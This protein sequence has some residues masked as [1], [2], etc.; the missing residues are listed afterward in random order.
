[1]SDFRDK[2]TSSRRFLRW[3]GQ[4]KIPMVTA[5]VGS[6]SCVA[7]SVCDDIYE[8]NVFTTIIFTMLAVLSLMVM[9]PF[10]RVGAIMSI[11]MAMVIDIGPMYWVSSFLAMV[12]LVCSCLVGGYSERSDWRSMCLVVAA[13]GT[14]TAFALWRASYFELFAL[15][16]Y[17]GLGVLP[18]LMG[19]SL[20]RGAVEKEAMRIR[21]ELEK[22]RMRL[23]E[24]RRDAA[25]ARQIHDSVTNDL[26]AIL[27]LVGSASLN[28]ANKEEQDEIK[29]YASSALGNVHHVIDL[30]NARSDGEPN[31]EN[32]TLQDVIAFCRAKDAELA[33]RGLSGAATVVGEARIS[34]DRLRL[35]MELLGEI[36]A[37]ILR[38][39]TPQAD[40]YAVM[41]RCTEEGVRL[42]QTNSC[43]NGVRHVRGVPSGKGLQMYRAEIEAI[44]G[45]MHSLHQDGGWIL[46]C[47]IPA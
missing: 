31:S 36:Y 12:L 23:D 28:D 30:L 25:L 17:G 35:V 26:S 1:M 42:V 45:V 40:E 21:F 34:G 3:L 9:V 43:K 44:G 19:R 2:A 13:C 7:I 41:L 11:I 33:K 16:L 29:T 38:H 27:L 32:P 24:Q 10:P 6:V 47:E 5:A 14:M 46:N 20:R 37:N 22:T 15:V 8:Y 18:W 4:R 39:C